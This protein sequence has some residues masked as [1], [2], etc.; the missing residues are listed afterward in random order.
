MIP[1]L[2]ERLFAEIAE[3]LFDV[4]AAGSIEVPSLVRRWLDDGPRVFLGDDRVQLEALCRQIDVRHRVSAVY[5]A[6]WKRADPET[7][8]ATPVVIG[9]VVVLLANA[10]DL[11]GAVGARD[12]G[13]GL[14]CVNSA[15]K[16]LELVG[17]APTAPAL[18]AWALS[19]VDDRTGSPT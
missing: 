6:G 4:T 19:V 15:L 5:D 8:A 1:S 17:D 10:G 12:G 11:D 14:K 2:T 16:A 13:W 7:P 3:T 9:L 18:R